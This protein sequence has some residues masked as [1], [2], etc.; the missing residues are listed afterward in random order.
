MKKI[1]SLFL[2]LA[3]L[4]TA[5]VPSFATIE[6]QEQRLEDLENQRQLKQEDIDA[7]SSEISLT[8]ASIEEVI[9][10]KNRLEEQIKQTDLDII[11]KQEDIAKV[12]AELKEARAEVLAQQEDFGGRLRVMYLNKD[13]ESFLSLLLKSRSIEDFLTKIDFMKSIADEDQRVLDDLKEKQVSIEKLEKVEQENL[14]DL[15]IMQESLEKDKAS[16]VA[17]E[18]ALEARRAELE[19]KRAQLEEEANALLAESESV[20]NSIEDLKAEAIRIAL[21]RENARIAAEEA[22]RIAAE[23][24]A[25][26]AAEQEAAAD[27]PD[28]YYPE[29]EI[30]DVNR[31][32]LVIPSSGFVWPAPGVY[33]I[34]SPFGWRADPF[35]GHTLF[36]NGTDIAGPTGSP[37]VAAASGIVVF[38]GWGN[39]YGNYVVISHP[40]GYETLYAHGSGNTVSAGDIVNAGDLI[41]YMGSTGYSTGPHLHFEVISG[42]QNIDPMS[43]VAP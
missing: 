31:G 35:Y 15:H 39:S 13:S 34:T 40:N 28:E 42:G 4:L 20:R 12:Q 10:E 33:L 9:A 14:A 22:A 16:L 11:E 36:H 17:V 26:I 30:P 19:A 25:R 6:E 29:P 24:A 18:Q 41:Q 3:L 23:E 32:D 38:S 2:V 21:E 43:V 37:I 8:Q 27:V 5:M 7:T 1:G